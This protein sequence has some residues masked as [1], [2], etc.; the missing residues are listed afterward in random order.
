FSYLTRSHESALEFDLSKAKERSMDNPVYYVQYAHARV[1]SLLAQAL[2]RGVRVGAFHATDF[3][4]LTEPAERSLIRLM[5]Q[6]SGVLHRAAESFEV[7][8]LTDYLT[9]LAGAYHHYY[10][11]H[12]ILSSEEADRPVMMARIGLSTAAGRIL[13]AGLSL[14]GVRAPDSM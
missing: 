7:H 1:K 11:H 8:P 14:L 3:A 6:F 4:P 5:A 12:R 10:F 9:A 13:A 2:G